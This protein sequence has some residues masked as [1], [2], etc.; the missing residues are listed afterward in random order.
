[1]MSAADN[2]RD[3][4]PA[5]ALTE[6]QRE[7][8]ALVAEGLT[9]QDI[10]DRLCLERHTVSDHVAQILWRLGATDRLQV[11]IWATRHRLYRPRT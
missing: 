1:M 4:I 11:A 9:N 10:A 8:A 2:I 3:D 6:R 7:V 5:S